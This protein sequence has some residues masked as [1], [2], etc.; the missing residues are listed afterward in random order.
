MNNINVKFY[1]NCTWIL[2]GNNFYCCHDE[3]EIVTHYDDHLGINGYYETEH[4]SYYCAE[5]GEQLDGN[6][7]EDYED[8]VVESQLMEALCS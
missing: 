7:D 8:L 4:K 6:P 1:P 3:I 2:E 5:C